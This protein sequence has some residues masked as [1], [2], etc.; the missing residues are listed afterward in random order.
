MSEVIESEGQ[1]VSANVKVEAPDGSTFGMLPTAPEGARDIRGNALVKMRKLVNEYEPDKLHYLDT[2]GS[3]YEYASSDLINHVTDKKLKAELVK[4]QVEASLAEGSRDSAVSNLLYANSVD[5]DLPDLGENFIL[6]Q[7]QQA[8]NEGNYNDA[9]MI[10][11]QMRIRGRRAVKASFD[12]EDTS[13]Q[14]LESW[15]SKEEEA[16]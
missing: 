13:K 4:I 1:M 7:Y 11:S 14:G 3:S 12:E 10:A 6:D 16:A 5:L 2:R 8:M 9:Y 15:R